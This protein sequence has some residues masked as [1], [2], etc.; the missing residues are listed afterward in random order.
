MRIHLTWINISFEDAQYIV[1]DPFFQIISNL[2]LK[3]K[4]ILFVTL[5]R[6]YHNSL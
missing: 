3:Y 6:L 5:Y 2:L 4:K 1:T